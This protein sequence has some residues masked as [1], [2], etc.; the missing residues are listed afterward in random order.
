MNSQEI[1]G[2]QQ[3]SFKSF[4]SGI[5]IVKTCTLKEYK[6]Y[7]NIPWGKSSNLRKSKMAATEISCYRKML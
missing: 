1:G 4:C 2:L 7:Q 6:V 3:N 5:D